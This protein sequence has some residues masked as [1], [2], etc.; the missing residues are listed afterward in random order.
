MQ[1]RAASFR[2]IASF[3]STALSVISSQ[4]YVF[5]R[6]ADPTATSAY[7]ARRS[8][9]NY[10]VIFKVH[11]FLV[12]FVLLVFVFQVVHSI[13]QHDHGSAQIYFSASIT[14]GLLVLLVVLISTT[15]LLRLVVVKPHAMIVA[16]FSFRAIFFFQTLLNG[17][18]MKGQRDSYGE[19]AANA[20]DAGIV[21][22]ATKYYDNCSIVYLYS[23]G[24]WITFS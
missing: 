22:C 7:L 9:S 4:K 14:Y 10:Q 15:I 18:E 19:C 1:M 3:R 8:L 16:A 11:V 12:S 17:F 21:V 23:Y 13:H 6:K 2:S 24:T 5:G 20:T